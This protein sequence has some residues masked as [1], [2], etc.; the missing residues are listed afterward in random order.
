L[1]LVVCLSAMN[2]GPATYTGY[3][4]RDYIS[5]GAKCLDGTPGLYYHRPG[6]GTGANKWYVHHEGGGWCVNVADCYKRSTTNLGSTSTDGPTVDINDS[7]FSIDPNVN[8]QMHN[9]NS[10]YLRYCDGAS[11]SGYNFTDTKYQNN[12]IYFRG[13][14]ILD[15]I[16]YDLLN[17]RNMNAATDVVISGCSAGGLATFLHVDYWSKFLT[18][19]GTKVRGMPDSGWFAD[20][21]DPVMRYH[22]NLVWV[23]EQ[24]NSTSGVNQKCIEGHQDEEWRCIFAEHTAPFLTTPVFPLQSRFDS[25]QTAYDLNSNDVA[26]INEFGSNM[27]TVIFDNLLA[28]PMHGIFLDSCYHHCG[29]WGSIVIDGLNQAQ[30]FQAWY[31]ND[32]PNAVHFQNE[33]YRCDKCCNPGNN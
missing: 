22:D 16:I 12:I 26:K 14:A 9:W 25:W 27:T 17:N 5:W 15:A 21:N 31:E 29:S 23:F 11:F 32:T 3:F 30:A 18:V 8:P 4:L 1:L 20:Y 2:A 6:T 10:V 13:K 7:Y 33:K 19:Q 28:N 24:N